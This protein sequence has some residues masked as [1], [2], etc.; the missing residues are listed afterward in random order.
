[1]M[2]V[3]LEFAY[4]QACAKSLDTLSVPPSHP[5]ADFKVDREVFIPRLSDLLKKYPSA[6]LVLFGS[7]LRPDSILQVIGDHEFLADLDLGHLYTN[8]EE[9]AVRNTHLSFFPVFFGFGFSSFAALFFLS[10]L[11]FEDFN[12]KFLFCILFLWIL[13]FFI[14]FFFSES[15]LQYTRNHPW[16]GFHS[17][18]TVVVTSEKD[19]EVS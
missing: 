9:A 10:F 7:M 19:T 3:A 17:W 11:Y 1:M 2:F 13:F 8:T 18:L 16:T 5:D 12:H 14:F 15:L 4:L 6:S